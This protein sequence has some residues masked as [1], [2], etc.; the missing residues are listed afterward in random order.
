MKT[1]LIV[2]ACFMFGFV[3]PEVL[4][5]FGKVRVPSM[6]NWWVAIACG[7]LAYAVLL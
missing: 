7:I 4:A 5:A 3:A 2:I 6:M 1:A